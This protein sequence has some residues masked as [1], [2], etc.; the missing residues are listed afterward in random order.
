M[1]LLPFLSTAGWSA[2]IRMMQSH[3]RMKKASLTEAQRRIRA[4]TLAPVI[5]LKKGG[6]GAEEAGLMLPPPPSPPRPAFVPVK[7]VSQL[8]CYHV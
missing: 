7:P 4:A 3:L 1:F 6:G 5:D 2:G 8:Y